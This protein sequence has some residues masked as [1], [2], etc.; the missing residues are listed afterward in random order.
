MGSRMI[1]RTC[2]FFDVQQPILERVC[3]GRAVWQ[4]D[5]LPTMTAAPTEMPEDR[6]GWAK[7]H[8]ALAVAVRCSRL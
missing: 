6:R 8:R 3:L 4:E 5:M 7:R 2:F 1:Y